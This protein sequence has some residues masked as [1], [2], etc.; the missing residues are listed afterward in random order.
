MY[1]TSV[2]SSAAP[3][4][5]RHS[6]PMIVHQSRQASKAR[7]QLPDPPHTINGTNNVITTMAP[8]VLTA[9]TR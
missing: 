3:P 8:S 2:T 7:R 1:S 4:T 9:K 5:S 6:P